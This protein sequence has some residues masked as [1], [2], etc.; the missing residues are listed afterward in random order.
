MLKGI[1]FREETWGQDVILR[2]D[3]IRTLTPGYWKWREGNAGKP[4]TRSWC[5]TDDKRKEEVGILEDFLTGYLQTFC[6]RQIKFRDPLWEKES[7]GDWGAAYLPPIPSQAQT[8]QSELFSLWLKEIAVQRS[9]WPKAGYWDSV[10]GLLLGPLRN[11]SFFYYLLCVCVCVC[12]CVPA[13]RLGCKPGLS[14]GKPGIKREGTMEEKR[15][16]EIYWLV[17][18]FDCLWVSHTSS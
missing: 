4:L 16:M 11:G 15:Y 18:P 17:I 5:L 14:G 8:C 1:S 9:R 7:C 2:Q 13:E 3:L 6:L 10:L 12:V